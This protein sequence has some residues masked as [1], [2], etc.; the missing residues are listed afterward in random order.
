[1]RKLII[2]SIVCLL[3]PTAWATQLA[4]QF[5]WNAPSTGGTP[6]GYKV[7]V[8]TS[9]GTYTSTY[10]TGNTDL[11]YVI[12]GGLADGTKYVAV[13]AYN[14]V[15]EGTKSSELVIHS[16]LTSVTGSG[17]VSPTSVWSAA[18]GSVQLTFTPAQNYELS[19]VTVNSTP[20][21]V[22]NNTYTLTNIQEPKSVVATFTELASPVSTLKISVW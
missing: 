4:T 5:A 8:G 21:T 19:T 13:S 18:G 12:T 17:E 1:M 7:Y 15:G 2:L 10:D 9:S 20:V 6:T 14:G 11:S 22:T 3:V 16:V